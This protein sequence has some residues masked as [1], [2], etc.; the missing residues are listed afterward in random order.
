MNARSPAHLRAATSSR[1]SIAAALLACATHACGAAPVAGDESAPSSVRAATLTLTRDAEVAVVAR[2][3]VTASVRTA[4]RARLVVRA[5]DGETRTSAVTPLDDRA[6]ARL[7]VFG[8][9]PSATHH[10]HAEFLDA[11]DAV[12]ERTAAVDLTTAALPRDLPRFNVEVTGPTDGVIVASAGLGYAV[13]AYAMVIDRAGRVLWYHAMGQPDSHGIAVVREGPLAIS[14]Y[15]RETF[16]RYDLATGTRRAL[17]PDRAAFLDGHDLATLADGAF[18]TIGYEDPRDEYEGGESIFVFRADGT[19]V[20]RW[21]T[22]IADGMARGDLH[23]NSLDARDATELLLSYRDVSTLALHDRATGRVR[24]TLGAAAGGLA[25]R[26]DPRGGFRGQ[27][28][29]RFLDARTILLFD[30]GAAEE[31]SRLVEYAIDENARTARMVWQAPVPR[32]MYS[33]TGGGAQRLPSGNTLG[34]ITVCERIEG[35]EMSPPNP[36][37]VVEVDRAGTVRWQAT[38]A[39]GAVYQAVWHAAL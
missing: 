35:V 10:A 30:N 33:S 16:G 38:L 34:T 2:A 9:A 14:V 17:A 12:V 26:D 31:G 7:V 23:P 22:Q 32:R 21:R 25:L 24:W 6:R 36:G 15:E 11:A 1:R 19:P 18:A 20:A 37:T 27:H 29:A 8:L 3:E 4:T 5:V 39:W 13:S 28:Y